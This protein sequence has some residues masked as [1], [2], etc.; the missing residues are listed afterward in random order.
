MV[1]LDGGHATELGGQ[2]GEALG[3]GG[4]G[5]AFVHVRPL[6]VLACG[7]SGQIL[8]GGADAVQLLE[9]Q[10]GVLL[11][12]LGGL[13]EEG[14]NLLK[15]LLLGLRGEVG[16]LVAGL[17]LTSKGGVQV[18]LGLG[19]G[20]GVGGFRLF[21]GFEL[22]LALLATRTFPVGWQLLK[23]CS[24]GYALCGVALSRVVLILA[25][26]AFVFLHCFRIL[27]IN[28]SHNVN[29]TELLCCTCIWNLGCNYS[30]LS[31]R[32][33][34]DVVDFLTQKFLREYLLWTVTFLP[35]S[36]VFYSFIVGSCVPKP[37][38][39]PVLSTFLHIVLDAVYQFLA[40]E[41]FEIPNYI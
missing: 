18:L 4:A 9:P 12:V 23:R 22:F 41:L 19:A 35:E 27:W 28:H 26:G 34:M 38:H 1:L 8:G 15:A 30:L 10:F 2:F 5:K 16:V 6:V 11:L 33:L 32:I 7:G 29:R 36:I 25:N 40:C 39:H 20:V 13:Q 3:F 14:G 37:V 17:A 21:D 31:V 24:R